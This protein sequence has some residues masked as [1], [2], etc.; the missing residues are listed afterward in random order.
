MKQTENFI[1]KTKAVIKSSPFQ[2]FKLKE[3]SNNGAQV[4]LTIEDECANYTDTITAAISD[5]SSDLEVREVVK[6]IKDKLNKYV[7]DNYGEYTIVMTANELLR[8]LIFSN[9]KVF[10]QIAETVD[11][12]KS[13]KLTVKE[14]C[15]DKQVCFYVNGI[16]ELKMFLDIDKLGNYAWRQTLRKWTLFVD[17]DDLTL[18]ELYKLSDTLKDNLF[19]RSNKTAKFVTSVLLTGED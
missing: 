14:F 12:G 5:E 2:F 3:V 15:Y 6:Y 10:N 18:D 16:K 11:L 4:E 19:K 1:N 13:Y 7:A 17:K 8:I 9:K